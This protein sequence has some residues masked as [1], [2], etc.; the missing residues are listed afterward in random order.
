MISTFIES[1]VDGNADDRGFIARD[2]EISR[3]NER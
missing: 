3:A 1:N 2:L